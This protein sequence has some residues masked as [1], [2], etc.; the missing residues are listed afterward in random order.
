MGPVGEIYLP[1]PKEAIAADLDGN[2]TEDLVLDYLYAVYALF[3]DGEPRGES[4]LPMGGSMLVAVGDLSGD[5]RP[6]LVVWG[7]EGFE[8]HWNS[9][10]GGFIRERFAPGMGITPLAARI[11]G[12]QLFVL[13]V[14]ERGVGK[15]VGMSPQGEVLFRWELGPEPAPGFTAADLDGDGGLDLLSLGP[16]EIRVSWDLEGTQV[17]R[18]DRG[19]LSL[20]VEAGD[21][22]YLVSTGE[23]ADVYRVSFPGRSPRVEGP[24]LQLESIPLAVGVGELDGDGVPDVAL[25]CLRFFQEGGAIYKGMVLGLL[26][27]RLG[28][29]VLVPDLPVGE[30]PLPLGGL[31]V[32]ELDGDGHGDLAV[33]TA[34]GSG[35]YLLFGDGLGGFAT[36]A[37]DGSPGVVY[38]ALARAGPL[39]AADLDGDGMDEL[40]AS[41]VGLGPFIKV[42]WGGGGG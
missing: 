31:A 12:G 36:R 40:V 41:T 14:D 6:E 5:G 17:Y 19:E 1:S 2:G 3:G 33:S 15:A 10:R 39:F 26:L 13:G 18:W 16:R 35:A 30:V 21:E 4:W 11:Q 32:G 38:P 20:A 24:L 8:V 29:K 7:R 27:S 34:D 28:V 37:P 25:A 23:Y 42:L 22:V 9:G